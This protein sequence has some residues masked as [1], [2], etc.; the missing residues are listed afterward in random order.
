M[1]TLNM[2]ALMIIKLLIVSLSNLIL[3]GIFE[4]Q[5]SYLLITMVILAWKLSQ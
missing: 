4:V 3:K 2:Y 5:S 1:S